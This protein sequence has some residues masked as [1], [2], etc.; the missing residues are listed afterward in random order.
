MSPEKKKEGLWKRI[1]HAFREKKQRPHYAFSKTGRLR[2]H[3]ISDPAM[4]R[5]ILRQ[6][7]KFTTPGFVKKGMG[8]FIGNALILDEG[9]SWQNMHNLMA[10]IFTPKGVDRTISP[11][12]VDECDRMVDRW[13]REG[14]P[15]DLEHEMRGLTARVVMRVVFSDS[16]TEKEAHDIIEAST[17]TIESFRKPTKATVAMR[18]LGLHVDHVPRMKREYR[19]AA[20]AIDGILDRIL[21][22]RRRLERQP[23]D[24]LGRLL[25][26]ND[27]ATGKPLTDKQIKDQLVMFIVA[28]HE[29][30]AVGLT[31]ALHELM[32][33]PAE[34]DK[35]RA[36]VDGVARGAHLG[37]HDYQKLPRVRDAFKE[38][39]RLHPSAYE[40][41]READADTIVGGVEI[42]KHDLVRMSVLDMHRSEDFWED[43]GEFRPERFAAN[44]FPQAYMPFGAGPRVCLGMTMAL[45]EG[46]LSLAEIF[47]RVD[48]RMTQE[49]EGE[50]LAFTMRPKGKLEAVP[51][52]RPLDRPQGGPP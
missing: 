12:V 33:K 4:A 39:L 28:G 10:D 2:V 5:E 23:D 49:P 31:F 22:E 38:A 48:L 26:A 8:R 17:V 37:G 14:K 29:T 46:T 51:R 52:P 44:P 11:V 21:D 35:I 41:G 1:V 34:I 36:E 19:D 24:I 9:E 6:D 43:A 3:E 47:N 27:A 40:I 13:L 30:T 45:T 20:A 16:I 7:K 18:A 32:K 15:L 42:K 25:T 50:I